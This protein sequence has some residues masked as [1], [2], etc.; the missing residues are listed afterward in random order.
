MNSGLGGLQVGV[1]GLAFKPGTDDVREAASIDLVCG[2]VEK[3]AK[4]K[5]FD[6]QASEAA[7]NLLPSSV[8]LADTPG[9]VAN[10]ARALV[11]FTEWPEIVGADWAPMAAGMRPPRFLFDGRN[12]LDA[13]RMARLGFEYMGVGRDDISRTNLVH[14]G[15]DDAV[16]MPAMEARANRAIRHLLTSQGE[17]RYA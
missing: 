12:A 4:V 13:R 17:L 15:E 6:P 8:D 7:R 16:T 14:T 5:V 3:G 2:I 9:E 11:L 10:G 1:L